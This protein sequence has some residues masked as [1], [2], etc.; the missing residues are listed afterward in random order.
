M[1]QVRHCMRIYRCDNKCDATADGQQV[2]AQ[3]GAHPRP[4]T[5]LG[6]HLFS[7]PHATPT[8]RPLVISSNSLMWE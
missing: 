5:C 4:P 8:S 7:H 6:F 2:L 3:P 1:L